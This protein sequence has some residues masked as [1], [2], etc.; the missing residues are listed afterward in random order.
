MKF[1]IT[2]LTLLAGFAMASPA[3]LGGDLEARVD[4]KHCGCSSAESCTFDVSD[5]AM[6]FLLMRSTL[7][8]PAVVVVLSVTEWWSWIPGWCSYQR[9]LLAVVWSSLREFKLGRREVGSNSY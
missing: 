6:P 1:S 4:C 3:A 2:V 5:N 9:Q 7:L 8:T